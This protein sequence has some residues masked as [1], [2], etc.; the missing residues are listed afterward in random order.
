MGNTNEIQ[1]ADIA[2]THIVN[3]NKAMISAA[4]TVLDGFDKLK[5][6]TD[7]PNKKTILEA[8]L[9]SKGITLVDL[10]TEV[11]ALKAIAEHI[12]SNVSDIVKL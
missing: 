2:I 3:M 5:A 11:V 4:D 8:G 6:F 9:L 10:Q 7:I 12:K 1:I